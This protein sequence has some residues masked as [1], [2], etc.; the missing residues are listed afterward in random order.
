LIFEEIKLECGYRADI[1]VAGKVVIEVK[2]IDAI[3][4]I[5]VA[6]LLTYLR[7]LKLKLGLLL[8]FNSLQIKSGIRRVVNGL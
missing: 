2:S 6:Q 1:V 3:A 5:H 7:L 8:N 4:E